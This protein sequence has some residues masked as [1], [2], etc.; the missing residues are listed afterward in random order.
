VY[1]K[2]YVE[3]SVFI[4]FIK[5]E[6]NQGPKQDKDAK[7]ILDSII[8]AAQAGKFKLVTSSLTIVEVFKKKGEK[9]PLT[10]E[11]NQDLRPYF[12]E[13]YIVLVEVNRSIGERANELCQSMTEDAERGCRALRPNDAIHIAAAEY[14]ECDVVLSWDTHFTS[15]TPRIK[16]VR[17]EHPEIVE[18]P[19]P[20][21]RQEKIDYEAKVQSEKPKAEEQAAPNPP[22]LSGSSVGPA[23]STPAKSLQAAESDEKAKK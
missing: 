5:G 9:Q 23:Q 3:S 16:T 14:A 18:P 2:P 20:V 21:M 7:A 4:A 13:E 6:K 11:Q 12:R 8:V 15:Q 1:K 19:A 22:A 17:L 10:Q